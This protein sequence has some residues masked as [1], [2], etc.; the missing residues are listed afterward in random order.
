M[1]QKSPERVYEAKLKEIDA[2][3][4]RMPG[5]IGLRFDRA[6]LLERLSRNDAAK[7]AYLEVLQKDPKHFGAINNLAMLLF[8][9]G[10]RQEAFLLYAE[11]A[12]RH[13]DNAVAHANLA[14]MFLKA[15]EPGR[16]RDH[17]E[18]AL[19]LDPKDVEAQRGL[20]A[21]LTQQGERDAARSLSGLGQSIVTLPY[22]GS[23][24][25]VTVLLMVTLG[26]GNVAAERLLDDRTFQVHKLTV[27]LH[28]LHTPLPAHDVI[29]NAIGDAD[30]AQEALA[31]ATQIIAASSAPVVNRP[32]VVLASGRAANAKRLRGGPGVVVPA[33][34]IIARD[35][36]AG[37]LG[38][39][40]LEARG[41]HLPVLL[42][43]PGFHTGRHFSRIE[44]S[45]ELDAAVAS[46]P[47]D[48]LLAIEYIDTRNALGEYTK[49]RVMYVN[50][51]MH[52]LHMA[53][54]HQ[55]KVHYFSSDMADRSDHREREAA[56]LSDMETAL[57][58]DAVATLRRIGEALG[59]EYAGI[60]FAIDGNGRIVVFEANATMI[61]A[62]PADEAR[63][64]YRREP[65]ERIYAAVRAMLLQRAAATSA[66]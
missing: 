40:A 15:N 4:R 27:E 39:A 1:A 36:L 51:E 22:R 35:L 56:F 21:V 28:A 64:A 46:L 32:D 29:F 10:Q 16:A 2:Q 42:R 12:E 50:G 44:R 60:D 58:H 62:M 54:G 8:K 57:G 13:P 20:A 34:D 66:S 25:P 33:I 61:V 11:A 47:G 24:K 14:F 6:T 43:S 41:F 52:P 26:A 3:I 59:L 19:A 38:T 48:N 30:E 55:W 63:W 23:G 49:Y 9:M 18:R 45:G 17:Y 7:A 37:P 65:V 53:I 31:K 5:A